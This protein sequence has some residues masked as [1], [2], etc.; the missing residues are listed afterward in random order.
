VGDENSADPTTNVLQPPTA[1]ISGL[2][3]GSYNSN[4]DIDCDINKVIPA[5]AAFQQKGSSVVGKLVATGPCGLNYPFQGTIEGNR[6]K[7]V[8]IVR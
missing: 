7:G 4:D 3:V 5:K 2:L 8:I 1:N 6:L